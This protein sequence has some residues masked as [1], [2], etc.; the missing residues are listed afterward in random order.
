M[1]QIQGRGEETHSMM[2]QSL[3][4]DAM[5]QPKCVSFRNEQSVSRTASFQLSTLVDV[6]QCFAWHV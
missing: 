4:S 2:D 5:H 1:G 3:Q 6:G